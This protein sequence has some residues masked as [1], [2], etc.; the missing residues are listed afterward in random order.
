M[1]LTRAKFD[2]LTHDLVERTANPVQAAL[3]TMQVSAA[4]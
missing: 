1:N 2:E 4:V 3:R